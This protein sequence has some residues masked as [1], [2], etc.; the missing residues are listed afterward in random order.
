MNKTILI[1]DDDEDIAA[2]MDVLLTQQGYKTVVA[3][4]A[5]ILK[6]LSAINPDLILLDNRMDDRF[7]KDHCKQLKTDPAT[8]RFKIVLVSAAADLESVSM[9]SCADGFLAKP[10]ELVSL[11]NLVK[12]LTN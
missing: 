9:E 11:I 4:S 1:L 5:A 2:L 3:T 10:F 6:D 7:G 8:S 12:D